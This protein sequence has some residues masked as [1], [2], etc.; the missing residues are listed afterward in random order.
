MNSSKYLLNTR[1]AM[2]LGAAHTLCWTAATISALAMRLLAH[3]GCGSNLLQ[4]NIPAS[5][6]PVKIVHTEQGTTEVRAITNCICSS[7]A[8][9]D[10]SLN[11]WDEDLPEGKT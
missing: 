9:K 3:L 6:D 1:K 7:R 8:D 2:L 5:K 11:A 10:T 4:Q